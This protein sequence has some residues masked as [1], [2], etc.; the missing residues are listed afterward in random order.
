MQSAG[1]FQLPEKQTRKK[2]TQK[3]IQWSDSTAAQP[4][5]NCPLS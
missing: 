2:V 5:I 4:V 1:L 3:P